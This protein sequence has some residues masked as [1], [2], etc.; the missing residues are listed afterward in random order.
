MHAAIIFFP[1]RQKQEQTRATHNCVVVSQNWWHNTSG[2]DRQS[3]LLVLLAPALLVPSCSKF[4]GN[5][6]KADIVV[7]ADGSGD[8]KTIQAAIASIPASN[9]ER[10]VVFVKNGTYREKIRVAASFVTLRGQSREGTRIE[11][12]QLKDDFVAHPDDLGWAVINLNR[13]NDFV[14][15][16]LTVEN[17]ASDM[18]AHAF[19]IYGTGDRTVIVDCN[20]LSHGGDTVALGPGE[21][22]R[23]YHA[24]CNFSGSVDFLC[25]RGW[26]F[27]T[28]CSFYAYKKTAAVWHDGSFDPDMKFV[29]RNCRFDGATGFNLGRHHVDAQFYFLGCKFSAKLRDNP[30]QRVTYPL[31][32]GPATE[33]D[34]R[35][36]ADLNNQNRWGERSYFHNCHRDRRDFNWFANNLSSAPGSPQP[37]EIS[38]AWTFGDKWN[39]EKESGPVIRQLRGM[40]GQIVVVFSEP[41]TVKGK[42][43]LKMCGSGVANY[44]SGSATDTLLFDRPPDLGDETCSIDLNGGAII[45][46]EASATLRPA[47]LS[48]RDAQKFTTN[49]TNRFEAATDTRLSRRIDDPTVEA[50]N[51]FN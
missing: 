34:I 12:P 42:P 9:R 48:L 38:A 36:N 23:Y 19:T 47:D 28:D 18:L 26:C 27:A 10:V 13:V 39:P 20:V 8:F 16:N 33:G 50:F 49:Y 32:A 37:K 3:V 22:G 14:L 2:M 6:P 25:P 35:H 5:L 4:A 24:R 1:A 17:T 30:I 15:E 31:K 21:P 51:E 29:L 43:Q 41:V 44:L 45:A 11:F 46:C 40:R 7:S